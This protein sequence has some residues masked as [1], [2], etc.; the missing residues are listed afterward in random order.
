MQISEVGDLPV[1][2]SAIAGCPLAIFCKCMIAFGIGKH[3]LQ[4]GSTACHQRCGV[5][6]PSTNL[7]VVA[8]TCDTHQARH[9]EVENLPGISDTDG[10][11]WR[12]DMQWRSK[13]VD[14]RLMPLPFPR[15]LEQL[16]PIMIASCSASRGCS[17][18]PLLTEQ[19][20]LAA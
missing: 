9:L 16:A 3:Q 15:P 4:P 12:P 20:D 14:F 7:A 19:Q 8:S 5:R 2:W 11:A 1:C 17:P 10:M 13:E 6:Q 18:R